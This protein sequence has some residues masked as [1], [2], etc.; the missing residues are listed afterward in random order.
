MDLE[1]YGFTRFPKRSIFIPIYKAQS[2]FYISVKMRKPNKYLSV[3]LQVTSW[4]I[5]LNVMSR[6]YNGFCIIT[7]MEFSRGAGKKN[8]HEKLLKD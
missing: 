1:N 5:K 8:C 7:T 4:L 6:Q 2:S 3:F